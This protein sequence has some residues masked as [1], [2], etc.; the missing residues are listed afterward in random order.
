MTKNI[1]V[2]GLSTFVGVGT[3][4][5]DLWIGNNLNVAGDLTYDEISGRNINITGI[6]TINNLNNTGVATF[7]N[8]V[9]FDS[10]A[11]LLVLVLVLSQILQCLN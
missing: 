3:F 6:A 8:D 4:L 10:H 11:G 9:H 1:K 2:T 7:R 5:G